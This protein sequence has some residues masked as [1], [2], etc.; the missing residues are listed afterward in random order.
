MGHRLLIFGATGYSGAIVA[1]QARLLLDGAWKDQGHTVVLAGRS[2]LKLARLG[3]RLG[4]TWR[5]VSLDH[6]TEVQRTLQG[7][8]VVI[9]CAGPFA[10]TGLRLARAC[11]L[12]GVHY[13]DICGELD[14]YDAI[15]ELGPGAR[16][17][18]VAVVCGAGYTATVSDVLVRRAIATLGD[19]PV[20]QV[21]VAMS[22]LDDVSRGSAKVMMRSAREQVTIAAGSGAGGAR[23]L[24]LTHVPV[25][26][27]QQAFDFGLTGADGKR[28]PDLRIASAANLLDTL[29]MKRAFVEMMQDA[30]RANLPDRVLSFIEM[31]FVRR[32]AYQLGALAAPLQDMPG[33]QRVMGWQLG[34]LPEG[35]DA[36][37]RAAR[38]HTMVL[39]ITGRCGETLVDWRLDSPDVYEVTA[40]CVLDVATR[41]PGSRRYGLRTPGTYIAATTAVPVDARAPFRNLALEGCV[42]HVAP[43]AAP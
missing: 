5:T 11:V 1:A 34:L 31:D 16:D 4:F 22:A 19:Q 18:D 24:R 30:D 36:A 37:D 10:F 38:R 6:D 20:G 7:F 27:L 21:K 40:R 8:D 3:A 25:G 2:R 13:V 42:L 17:R 29:V 26:Q 12:A 14:A 39:K 43:V 33:W 41:M 28:A 32:T 9:N 35:P 15:G 23:E